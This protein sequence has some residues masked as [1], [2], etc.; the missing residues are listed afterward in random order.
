MS[1]SDIELF[2]SGVRI[3]V[4]KFAEV[5]NASLNWYERNADNIK[6]YIFA[7]ADFGVWCSA[8][9]KMANNQ[10]IFTDDLSIEFANEIYDS[11]DIDAVI[12]K[13]YS[14]N[15]DQRLNCVIERCKNSK[16]IEDYTLLFFQTIEAYKLGHYHLACV[17][18]FSVIDGIL[19]DVTNMI[20]AT[21]F[22]RRIEAV[23][24][25]FDAKIE[26]N[27]IDRRTLC[28]Y[29]S[30]NIIKDSIF[31]GSD[32]SKAEP[33]GINR[34]W[35]MHGRTRRIYTRCDFLKVLLLLDAIIFLSSNDIET[36]K[37][38]RI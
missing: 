21:N 37:E 25:K 19:A 4:S 18:L 29:D 34:H 1:L 9:E 20:N 7:F 33:S 14:E 27:D 3:F 35:V 5:L 15:D 11:L 23:N 22:K 12:E 32:F 16:K 30:V 17:G 36:D 2:F 8:V 38:L 31:G 28:I 6:Q 10:I 24:E 13:Y 26:L